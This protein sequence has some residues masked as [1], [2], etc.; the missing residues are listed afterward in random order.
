MRA[1]SLLCS[2]IAACAAPLPAVTD[3]DDEAPP[4]ADLAA[5]AFVRVCLA[6]VVAGQSVPDMMAINDL[7]RFEDRYGEN[8]G[9]RSFRESSSRL[10]TFARG[11]AWIQPRPEEVWTGMRLKEIGPTVRSVEALPTSFYRVAAL[12][13]VVE[14]TSGHSDPDWCTVSLYYG[15]PID[16]E[17]QVLEF[18][19]SEGHPFRPEESRDRLTGTLSKAGIFRLPPDTPGVKNERALVTL[20]YGTSAKEADVTFSSRPLNDS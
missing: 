19:R 7:L 3:I 9:V 11:G 2:L 10:S 1:T 5:A 20:R 17:S 4:A 14:V 15:D 8:V 13:G 16:A 12:D 18:L 6:G